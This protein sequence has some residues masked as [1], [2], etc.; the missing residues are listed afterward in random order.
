[1]MSRMELC[2]IV[3]KEANYR[4][5]DDESGMGL[6]SSGF[7]DTSELSIQTTTITPTGWQCNQGD[8][9]VK[10]LRGT[11]RG[12]RVRLVGFRGPHYPYRDMCGRGGGVSY[13]EVIYVSYD[14]VL[15]TI[16]EAY[17]RQQGISASDI[18]DLV[19]ELGMPYDE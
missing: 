6:L 1:M 13:D 2:E 12:P 4:H 10:P 19:L 18:I 15:I 17:R 16:I 14:D 11:R 7:A 8:V 3:E 5:C 9:S